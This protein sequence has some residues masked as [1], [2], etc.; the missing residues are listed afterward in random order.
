MPAMILSHA[1][2]DKGYVGRQVLC[3][4]AWSYTKAN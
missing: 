3:I 1:C 2:Y 4:K